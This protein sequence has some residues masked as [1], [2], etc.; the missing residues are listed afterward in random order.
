M[1]SIEPFSVIPFGNGGVSENIDPPSPI[2]YF[3]SKTLTFPL[4]I[5][6]VAEFDLQFNKIVELALNRN[7]VL[8][9]TVRR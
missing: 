1:F 6:T 2:V 8:E 3:N 5:N 9:F 4:K 7:T